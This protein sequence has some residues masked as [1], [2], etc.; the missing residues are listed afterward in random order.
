MAGR[1]LR[2][3]AAARETT[4]SMAVANLTGSNRAVLMITSQEVRVTKIS[5]VRMMKMDMMERT[6]MTVSTD[7]PAS[8][9]G[10]MVLGVTLLP[11]TNSDA[12][13]DGIVRHTGGNAW[14]TPAGRTVGV[15]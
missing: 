10:T 14:P 12:G 15:K 1:A 2:L 6:V 7:V 5:E 3:I 4:S 13:E 9:K 8:L 11:T